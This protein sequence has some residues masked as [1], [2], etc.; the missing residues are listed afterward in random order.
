MD[1]SISP[2]WGEVRGGQLWQAS[3][4]LGAAHF[5]SAQV[6]TL[7]EVTLCFVVLSGVPLMVKGIIIPGQ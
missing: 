4:S 5:S 7:A 3:S 2:G 1:A 6:R